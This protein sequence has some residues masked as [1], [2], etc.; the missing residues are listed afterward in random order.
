MGIE[1]CKDLGGKHWVN[2]GVKECA[3]ENIVSEH[4]ASADHHIKMVVIDILIALLK[5]NSHSITTHLS[6]MYNSM[7]FGIITEL[8]NYHKI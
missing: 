8:C 2:W 6:K 4:E 7:V 5:Y 1:L 3:Q